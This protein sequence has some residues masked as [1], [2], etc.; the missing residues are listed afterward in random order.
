MN[1]QEFQQKMEQA[2]RN[3]LDKDEDFALDPKLVAEH[4]EEA[5]EFVNGGNNPMIIGDEN[6][7]ENLAVLM[8]FSQVKALSN[9]IADV[10][11]H[12][13]L[14]LGVVRLLIGKREPIKMSLSAF[15]LDPEEHAQDSIYMSEDTALMFADLKA[16][17]EDNPDD[18]EA[19]DILDQ[20]KSIIQE[21][22][23]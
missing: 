4:I 14:L 8:S 7:E 13:D 23:S 11:L 10:G 19:A 21:F 12:L 17:I 22:V 15:D 18:L 9:Q 1:K 3:F 16:H 6:D 20:L 5:I 2:Q